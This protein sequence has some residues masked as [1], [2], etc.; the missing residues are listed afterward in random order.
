MVLGNEKK[1]AVSGETAVF[2]YNTNFP[3]QSL[4]GGV[5]RC[6]AYARM[7]STYL[8]NVHFGQR[9]LVA[10]SGRKH[11]GGNGENGGDER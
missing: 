4:T 2:F 10:V 9:F 3:K 6:A 5:R 1:T 11:T 7:R 8:F